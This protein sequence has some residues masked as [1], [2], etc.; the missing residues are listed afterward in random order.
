MKPLGGKP[1][2]LLHEQLQIWTEHSTSWLLAAGE[3]GIG[4]GSNGDIIV[5]GGHCL[6]VEADLSLD[7]DIVLGGAWTS[8]NDILGW[9]FAL[10]LETDAANFRNE[11]GTDEFGGNFEN[12]YNGDK[13]IGTTLSVGYGYGY[14]LTIDYY[15]NYDICHRLDGKKNY[16]SMKKIVHWSLKTENKREIKNN[17]NIFKSLLIFKI[18]RVRL[19]N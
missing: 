19:K 9:N 10:G 2:K 6:G 17:L 14:D 7:L 18:R 16:N 11:V 4:I 13:V 3:V 15:S 12:V 5:F 1:S 8:I